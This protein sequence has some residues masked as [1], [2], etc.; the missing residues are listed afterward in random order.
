VPPYHLQA[1]IKS[2]VATGQKIDNAPDPAELNLTEIGTYLYHPATLRAL[3]HALDHD[4]QVILQRTGR[5][6]WVA[7]IAEI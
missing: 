5:L 6:R 4:E 3:L 1:V 7:P 2:R